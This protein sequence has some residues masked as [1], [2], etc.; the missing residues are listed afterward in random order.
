MRGIIRTQVSQF[1]VDEVNS[2]KRLD[3]EQLLDSRLRAELEEKGFIFDQFVLRNITF[4][5]EYATAVER[6]QVAL[7]DITQKQYEAQQIKNLAE[8]QAKQITIKA[9]AEAEAKL[10]QA[11]AE[12]EALKLLAEA[13]ATNPALL[14]YR[15]IDKLSPAIRVMLVPNNAPFILPLPTPEPDEPEG[16]PFNFNPNA[17]PIPLES[18]L[19]ETP[20][21]RA[22]PVI[23]PTQTPAP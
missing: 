5:E 20:I 4:S 8:G 3:L 12:A 9:S 6:K 7:Q 23:P 2:S 15:Y 18:L 13:L 10:V 19:P 14:T 11:K 16:L 21:M 1:T 22:T 17:T